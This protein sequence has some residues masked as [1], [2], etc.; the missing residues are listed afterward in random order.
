MYECS[1]SYEDIYLKNNS[2]PL[3]NSCFPID[4]NQA[5]NEWLNVTPYCQR[6]SMGDY[7]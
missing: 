4:E 7:N 1:Q 3:P 2:Q 6:I 5:P